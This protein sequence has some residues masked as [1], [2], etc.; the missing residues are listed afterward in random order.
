MDT[1]RLLR[2][3]LPGLLYAFESALLSTVLAPSTAKGVWLGLQGDKQ[4][5]TLLGAALTAFFA[6]GA[7][8][9]L[10]SMLHHLALWWFDERSLDYTTFV[11]ELRKE[12]GGTVALSDSRAATGP[13]NPKLNGGRQRRAAREDAAVVVNELWFS[14]RNPNLVVAESRLLSLATTAHALGTARVAALAATVTAIVVGLASTSCCS[15]DLWPVLRVGAFIAISVALVVI[16]HDGFRRA[17]KMADGLLRGLVLREL[18]SQ[19]RI[20]DQQSRGWHSG[21]DDRSGRVR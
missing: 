16:P 15:G 19:A 5:G 21:R 7:V 20:R 13:T 18:S 9:F 12:F 11:G 6:S 4:F 17:A 14:L 3:V 2:Y 8:G 1:A 10:L